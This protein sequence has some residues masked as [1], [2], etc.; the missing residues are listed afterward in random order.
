MLLLK[1]HLRRCLFI[2]QTFLMISS[3]SCDR[4]YSL[5]Q[6]T[7]IVTFNEGE[8][9]DTLLGY[10]IDYDSLN[11]Q[12]GIEC[13][14]S[15]VIVL[16]ERDGAIFSVINAYN[17]SLVSQFGMYGHSKSE[18][19][20]STDMCQ[21]IHTKNDGIL[22]C[23]QDFELDN[24]S[25]YDLKA[26]IKKRKTVFE[27][28]LSYKIDKSKVW[29][30]RCFLLDSNNY[31]L[32]KG[33]SSEGDARDRF[34]VPPCFTVHSKYKE[35]T[36]SVY[37]SAIQTG[38]NHF[39]D[40]MY[41]ELPRISPNM[42]KVVEMF[43]YVNLFTIVDLDTY[44]TI[45]VMGERSHG[46][47]YY[48]QLAKDKKGK[49]LYKS[50]FIHNV[51]FNVSDNYIIVCQ[52][53]N[54]PVSRFEDL[55]KYKPHVLFFDWDGNMLFSFCV[56]APLM[57]IAYNDMSKKLYGLTNNGDLYGYDLSKYFQ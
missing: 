29:N 20:N 47:E 4:E 10:K 34:T 24:I 3:T 35:F 7:K 48:Q 14:D 31:L 45:G 37:P 46:L 51:A 53:G 52:D 25:V 33:L 17:D 40:R 28:S 41:A 56:N 15:F 19:L 13:V 16:G 57:R 42:K 22:M 1:K 43:A 5:Y 50:V 30:Y 32:Y 36:F 55:F 2:V 8:C 49:E 21:F 39:M 23:V 54:T 6:P 9:L 27:K 18:F 38:D 11:V 44:K 12:T 26:S